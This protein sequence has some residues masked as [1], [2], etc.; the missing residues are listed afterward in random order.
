MAELVNRFI[1]ISTEY[2]FER[3][4]EYLVE[5]EK[6]E[7]TINLLDKRIHDYLI[8]LI[9]TDIDEKASN[10]I[11]RYLDQIKD[12]ERLG[13]HCKNLLGFFKERY[14][15]N[16]ELSIDGTQ[17][18]KQIYQVLVDMSDLTTTAIK[19]WS[20]DEAYSALKC[21]DEIDKLEE[22]FHGRHVYRVNTGKCSVLN[23]E[24]FVEVLANIERMGDHLE[25]ICESIIIENTFQYDEFNH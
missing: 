23:S 5:G 15:N 19:K 14:E 24:H 3:K 22:V 16:M 17:D 20:S 4:D 1:H 2:S 13:D 11:S 12:F 21:E 8:K 6:I 10:T 18:L 25:N 7:A 9:I